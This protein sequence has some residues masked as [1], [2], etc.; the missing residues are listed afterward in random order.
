[1]RKPVI[2][3][4]SRGPEEE[5]RPNDGALPLIVAFDRH[6]GGVGLYNKGVADGC[7]RVHEGKGVDEGSSGHLKESTK[8]RSKRLPTHSRRRTGGKR[9]THLHGA[10]AAL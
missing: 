7:W 4:N 10:A 3:A 2:C 6:L 1:M 8:D 5:N 9:V